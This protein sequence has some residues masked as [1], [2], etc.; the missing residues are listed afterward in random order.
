MDTLTFAQQVL[1][2]QGIEINDLPEYLFNDKKKTRPLSDP[3]DRVLAHY[4]EDSLFS[5]KTVRFLK[6]FSR[7]NA[8][9]DLKTRNKSFLRTAELF[10]RMGLKNHYFHLQLNNPLLSGVDPWDPSLTDEVKFMITAEAYSNIWYIVRELVRIDD[11]PFIGNRAVISFIWASLNHINTLILLPRQSGKESA[12]TS[13]IKIPGGWKT[14]KDIHP[15]DTILAPDGTETTV[16]GVYPQGEK[17]VYVMTFEDGREHTCGPEHLWKI[18]DS[19]KQAWEVTHTLDVLERY[20]QAHPAQDYIAIPLIEPEDGPRT[21]FLVIE[22][23]E[24]GERLTH[25]NFPD[26]QSKRLDIVESWLN[27]FALLGKDADSYYIPEVYR[28][29]QCYLDRLRL[30]QGIMD[31]IGK[32]LPNGKV[33]CVV[34]SAL[35]A[36]HLQY[37]IRSLGM[38]CE[39]ISSVVDDCQVVA[40]TER[41]DTAFHLE[42][43]A[44]DMTDFF[45]KEEKK[46]LVSHIAERR[47]S[48]ELMNRLIAM[49]LL[50]KRVN[51]RCIEVDHPD[52][53]YVTD[54]FI[55]THN[56]VGMQ[57]LFFI[58][59]YIVGRGYK[60]GL[61]TLA[62]KNRLNFVNAVKRIRSSLPAY[63]VKMSY[64]DKDS[65][66]LLTYQ[67]HGQKY[68]NTFEIAVPNGGRD[69][70]ETVA[71]GSTFG[72][73]GIDE[74]AWTKFI[75]NII[76]G[77]GPATL[78]E[79]KNM[80]ERGL[81]WFTCMA[82]TPNSVLKEEGKYMYEEYLSS[83][84]WKE[85]YF[86][87]FSESHLFAALIKNSPK[88]TTFPK[89]AI[90]YNHLQLGF[91]EDWVIETMDRLKLTWSKAKIDLLMMWTEEGTHNIFDEKTRELLNEVKQEFDH[92]HLV[93]KTGLYFSWF[94]SQSKLNQYISDPEEFM[95]MGCDTSDAKSE[96]NDACTITLRRCKTGEVLGVGRYC[97][98]FL[99]D[100]RDV[101]L[102]LIVTIPN[103]VL[104]IEN[105]RAQQI[106][107]DLLTLLP[108]LGIDPFVRLYN[109]IYQNPV[110]YHNEFTAVQQTKF[111]SRTKAFY[112]RYKGMFG[113]ATTGQSREV[114]YGL[115]YESV[116]NTGVGCR[117][118]MLIDEL[119]GLTHSKSGRI[120]H[121]VKGQDDIVISWLLSYWFMKLGYNKALYKMPP[122]SVLTEMTPLANNVSKERYTPA[123]I[124]E[125]ALTR[126][127]IAE[128]TDKLVKAE[129]DAFFNRTEAL[130]RQLTATLPS[131]IKKLI[132]IDEVIDNAKQE[133]K[134]RTIRNM[135]RK[136][137]GY[138]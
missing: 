86:D 25:L 117:Y 127:K 33:G 29:N 128:L 88:P 100:V 70:A 114:L 91:G 104:V 85:S 38:H 96:K 36:Q 89:V 121:M 123:Q 74:P 28:E 105:N 20:I 17:P 46:T 60:S 133:R 40:K 90:Q 93:E 56:T 65:G 7:Y 2:H 110:K 115:I 67:G 10:K 45:Y 101:L 14:L 129:S 72:A 66:N 59:Q 116:A 106:I 62:S 3:D 125:F 11:R 48:G 49:R 130:I 13:Q 30:V 73:L 21:T 97:L 32:I 122:L 136:H 87:T 19:T 15:G 23:Y 112:L 108:A 47:E 54:D 42:C 27:S 63:L 107:D 111:R 137:V 78:K 76:S 52:H 55:V 68:T 131:E 37:V 34:W 50:P 82:T 8:A 75:G 92:S 44:K 12:D 64:K 80:A 109:T 118:P 135:R 18:F 103:S 71:R 6:D 99:G 41:G 57:T 102:H 132:T 94:I 58:M 79:Q 9:P 31:N 69:G 134:K 83:T 98:A 5:L 124:K 39:I 95:V 26:A 113:F 53:L 51:C 126:E 1:S 61:I 16:T 119:L 43:Q 22:P 120:D 77:S 81:P 24:F 4:N 35:L 138:R 84:Q